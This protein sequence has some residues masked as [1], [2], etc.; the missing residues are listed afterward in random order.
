MVKR[1]FMGICIFS[2]LT[3]MS[4]PKVSYKDR[5]IDLIHE[6]KKYSENFGRKFYII[7][8]NG[9]SLIYLNQ[10][11][12]TYLFNKN[13]NQKYLS[14][15][16][17]LTYE[18]GDY[19]SF[20]NSYVHRKLKYADKSSKKVF[21]IGYEEHENKIE[22]IYKF[23]DK[24]DYPVYISPSW[25]LDVI[26]ELKDYSKT[27]NVN[28][29]KDVKNFI[30]MINPANYRRKREFLKEL[31]ESE[32]DLLII[33][34]FFNRE[35]ITAEEINYLKI[36]PNG[37]KRIVLAY[38]SVGEAENYRYYWKK[39]WNRKKPSFIVKR[40]DRWPNSYIV[41]FWYMR[42][43]EILEGYMDKINQSNF[44]GVVFD[45]VDTHLYFEKKE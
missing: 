29:L 16:D 1:V 31:K 37:D 24:K 45:V 14:S 26:P 13:I 22:K 35:I 39:R 27:N 41:K 25:D 4:F 7:T 32:Y 43:W 15:I 19:S 2:I 33:D 30:Y 34:L 10:N 21:L 9:H 6:L 36:K 3:G 28:D 23:G 17:G 18:F 20:L 12:F 38:L 44:D 40:N 42:W 8:Q 11:I 5:M